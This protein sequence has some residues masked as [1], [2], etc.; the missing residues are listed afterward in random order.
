MF[1][2]LS[3]PALIQISFL[4]GAIGNQFITAAMAKN[5][6][7]FQDRFGHEPVHQFRD[8][9]KEALRND[10]VIGP[11]LKR[12]EMREA[13]EIGMAKKTETEFEGSNWEKFKYFNLHYKLDGYATGEAIQRAL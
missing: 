7:G 13:L 9:I 3:T 8:R 1:S 11:D 5:Y 10:P 12:R 6:L 4:L 2:W